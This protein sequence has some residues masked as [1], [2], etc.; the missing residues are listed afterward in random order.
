MC[1]SFS[2]HGFQMR[3]IQARLVEERLEKAELQQEKDA[4][5]VCP[6]ACS[7]S[8]TPQHYVHSR[9]SSALFPWGLDSTLPKE[10]LQFLTRSHNSSTIS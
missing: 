7:Q 5:Q 6:A 4:L 9:I 2:W 1:L 10:D 8:C 3:D